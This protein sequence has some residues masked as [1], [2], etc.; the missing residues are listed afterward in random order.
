MS[1]DYSVHEGIRVFAALTPVLPGHEQ[2]LRGHLHSLRHDSPFA[3]LSGVHYARWVLIPELPYDGY[4]QK[5]D[6]LTSHYLLFTSCADETALDTYLEQL[7]DGLGAAGDAVWGHC[8]G[9]GG[10]HDLPRYLLH[11]QLH[12]NAVFVQP[13]GGTVKRVKEALVLHDRLLRF[14]IDHQRGGDVETL[15]RDWVEEFGPPAQV[16]A[17]VR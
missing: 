4:P 1:R 15:R 8:T 5:P 2:A 6:V 14:V 11:N 13:V 10:L 7:R 17:A 9:Y 12:P 3:R 16:P